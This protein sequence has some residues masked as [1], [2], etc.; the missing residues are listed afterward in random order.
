MTSAANNL[1]WSALIFIEIGNSNGGKK[2]K[3]RQ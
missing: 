1:A 2:T 3:S